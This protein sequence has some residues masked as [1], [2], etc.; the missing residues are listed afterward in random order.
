MVHVVAI[1]IA[2]FIVII[3]MSL[4]VPYAIDFAI[5]VATV[6]SLSTLPH[7]LIPLLNVNRMSER[8]SWNIEVQAT[9]GKGSKSPAFSLTIVVTRG[10]QPPQLQATYPVSLDEN[11]AVGFAVKDISPS[12]NNNNYKY[13]IIDGNTDDAFC[14][15]HD[16][17][18]S[19]AKPLDREIKDSYSLK[20]SVS[21]GNKVTNTTVDV[22][23][24]DKNDDAP[25]FT[26]PVYTFDVSE[27]KG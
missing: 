17:V 15:N 11:K 6:I 7:L 27:N 26:K 1:T 23:I 10:V 12:S 13:R 3:A 9:D 22:T 24:R 20:V 21:V 14:I 16:G 25:E 19:V 5:V 4:Q 8:S 2:I 18:I